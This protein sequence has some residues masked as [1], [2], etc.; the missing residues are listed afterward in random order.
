[1]WSSSLHIFN[2]YCLGTRRKISE[3]VTALADVRLSA[4]ERDTLVTAKNYEATCSQ[5]KA[6]KILL[7]MPRKGLGLHPPKAWKFQ[8]AHRHHHDL[9][10]DTPQP[11]CYFVHT[12]TLATAGTFTLPPAMS[13]TTSTCSPNRGSYDRAGRS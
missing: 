5:Q 12:S 9:H 11:Y 1:M 10:E 2:A 4:Q 3:L 6:T 8:V 13:A 7:T